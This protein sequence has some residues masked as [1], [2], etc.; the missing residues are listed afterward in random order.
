MGTQGDLES[1]SGSFLDRAFSCVS[2][3][4]SLELQSSCLL[5]LPQ[6]VYLLYL[7]CPTTFELIH[8]KGGIPD[9]VPCHLV[10][11]L[12]TSEQSK[13]LYQIGKR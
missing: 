7:F 4:A 10:N 11:Y 9:A 2:S 1:L 5:Q 6:L 3:A 8:S 12:H 13:C